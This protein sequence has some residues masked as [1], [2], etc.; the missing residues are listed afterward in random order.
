MC[1][2]SSSRADSC[3]VLVDEYRPILGVPGAKNTH[4]KFRTFQGTNK[5]KKSR[6][7]KISRF[8]IGIPQVSFGGDKRDRTADLLNAIG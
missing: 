5:K 7:P 4:G 2:N 8:F 3:C 1:S 6:N